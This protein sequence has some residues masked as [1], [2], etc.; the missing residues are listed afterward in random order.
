MCN[1]IDPEFLATQSPEYR[2]AV[3]TGRMNTRLELAKTSTNPV[4]IRGHNLAAAE[5]MRE[6]YKATARLTDPPL[7][8]VRKEN[9]VRV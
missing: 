6:A 9:G 7:A 5:Y 3:W 2:H 1:I 8:R 4:E